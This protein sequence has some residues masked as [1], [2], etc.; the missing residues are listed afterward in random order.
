M[1]DSPP[2][3]KLVFGSDV[4][5]DGAFIELSR[6]EAGASFPIIEVFR[7]D[8]DGRITVTAEPEPIPPEWIN[9]LFDQ[10]KTDLLRRPLDPPRGK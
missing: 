4:D 9:H 5:R 6:E 8:T 2:T 1:T 3:Y 7:S 10:T